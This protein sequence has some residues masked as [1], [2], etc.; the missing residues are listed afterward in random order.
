M[1]CRTPTYLAMALSATI[2]CGQQAAPGRTPDAATPPTSATITSSTARTVSDPVGAAVLSSIRVASHPGYDRVVFEFHGSPPTHRAVYVDRVT[3]D[4][5][6]ALVPLRGNAFLQ[7]T[8]HGATMDNSFQV[9]DP[10]R[11]MRYDGPRRL[12]PRLPLVQDIAEAGDFEADLTFGLGLT[13]EAP[14]RVS[15]LT[16]PTRVVVDLA[17]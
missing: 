8:L 5:S 12:T 1:L 15:V 10:S 17:R 7:L 3:R 2:A 6:G 13:R 16:D 11:V 4:G 14:V 9:T